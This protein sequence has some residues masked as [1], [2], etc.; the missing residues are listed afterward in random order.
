MTTQYFDITPFLDQDEGQHYDR[1]SLYEGPAGRKKPRRR[2]AVRDQVAE[3][4]AAFANADGGVLA[5]GIEDD[6][7]TVTGHRLPPDALQ[8]LLNTPSR[9]LQPA[10]DA[11][12]TVTV[13]DKELIIFDVPVSDVPVQVIGNGFP[14]RIADQV[15]QSSESQINALKFEGM[16]ASWESRP[17]SAALADLD[18]SLL[19]QARQGAGQIG[20]AHV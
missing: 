8:N 19:E 2:R 16:T 4:V 15:V 13:D 17:T 7:R 10:Q 6:D 9:R 20:R 5:L 12:F 11:G 18:E 1:K 3:Y 14:L